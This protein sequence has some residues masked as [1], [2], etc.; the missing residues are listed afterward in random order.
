VSPRIGDYCL[1]VMLEGVGIHSLR[2]RTEHAVVDVGQRE[3]VFATDSPE[4]RPHIGNRPG[5][6][7]G[8]QSLEAGEIGQQCVFPLEI[9]ESVLFQVLEGLYRVSQIHRHCLLHIQAQSVANNQQAGDSRPRH[10]KH[11]RSQ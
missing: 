10:D 8:H 2:V 5:V 1:E 9:R 7:S 11:E 3:E 6:A 4:V